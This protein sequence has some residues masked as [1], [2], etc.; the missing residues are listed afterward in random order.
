MSTVVDKERH[1]DVG[2]EESIILL[3]DTE[4]SPARPSDKISV[5]EKTLQWLETVS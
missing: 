1:S 5:K 3:E 4:A 2:R